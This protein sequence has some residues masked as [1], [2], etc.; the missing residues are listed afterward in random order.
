MRAHLLTLALTV[1]AAG[2]LSSTAAFADD[3]KAPPPAK[4]GDKN[5]DDLFGA[6]PAKGGNNNLD[7]MKKATDGMGAKTTK[8]SGL[9][10]KLGSIDNDAPVTLLNVFAAEHIVQDKKMGCQAG[11]TTKKKVVEWDFDD[12]PAKGK[13][14]EVC[15]TLTSQAGREM[16]M[17]IAIVDSRNVR[18]AN[19]EDVI[20]FRGRQKI[21]H[22]LEYPAPMFKSAGQYFYV[23]DLD[24]KEIGR[25]P[26]FVVKVQQGSATSGDPGHIAPEAKDAPIT[27][28]EPDAK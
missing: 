12:V 16:N 10:A 27:A 3:K 21:D 4:G 9:D 22:V 7:A 26:I 17:H 19:A 6:P 23:V 25:L 15:L 18:I 28:K 24:G 8:G 1:A 11:G 2:A 5:F 13:N 14:F 20:D